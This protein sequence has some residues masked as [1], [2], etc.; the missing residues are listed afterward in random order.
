MSSTTIGPMRIQ[1]KYA[2][3][4]RSMKIHDVS[5]T[6]RP[7]MPVWPNEKGPEITPLRR[8]AKGDGANVS[9]VSFANHTGT[10]VDP[11]VHFIEGGNTVDR[12]P[13]A[14]LVGP[15]AVVHYG[16]DSH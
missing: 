2:A 8:I 1:R 12:L 16:G 7:G 9:V 6:L 5:L 10:H 11:P 14:S 15:C 13:L 3:S 4:R